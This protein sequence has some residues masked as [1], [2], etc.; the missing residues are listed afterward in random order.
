MFSWLPLA[1]FDRNRDTILGIRVVAFN[2]GNWMTVDVRNIN[3]V[4]FADWT[5]Y[6]GVFVLA[7]GCGNIPA[8]LLLNS[9]TNLLRNLM[10]VFLGN[11]ATLLLGDI[12]TFLTWNF[13]AFCLI[14]NL[15]ADLLVDGVTLLSIGGVAL[16]LVSCVTFTIILSPA[17]LLWNLVTLSFI[18]KLTIL[19]RN[20]FTDFFF[21][22]LTFLLVK[23]FAVWF[24]VCD[25]L[26]LLHIFAFVLES[27]CTL[28]VIFG[29]AFLLV[30]GFLD[31]LWNLDTLKLGSAVTFF[32]RDCG[33]F[34]LDVLDIITL[35]LVMDGT[36]LL[37]GVL[38]NRFLL[39]FTSLCLSLGTNLIRNISTFLPGH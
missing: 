1:L 11:L 6:S 15:L 36:S 2:I 34:L 31:N 17:F 10:A 28:V 27:Y 30:N 8:L 12:T 21:H 24:K 23:N 4:R 13:M 35:L 9:L 26:P 32:I 39:D 25:T 3:A 16:L 5:T 20:V 19:V 29:G 7:V 37:V 22:V 33:T 18:D 38:L 14:T